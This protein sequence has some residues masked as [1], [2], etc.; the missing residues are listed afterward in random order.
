M[1]FVNIFDS[2]S[3]DTVITRNDGVFKAEVDVPLFID[4]ALKEL[5]RPLF[6]CFNVVS[7]Q[8]PGITKVK[9]TSM[10]FNRIAVFPNKDK[11]G[12]TGSSR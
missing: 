7:S 12:N 9:Y 10:Q 6:N 3:H 11:L 1:F 5:M 2:L 8:K 4:S